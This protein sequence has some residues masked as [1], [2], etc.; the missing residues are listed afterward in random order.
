M[1]AAASVLL[2]AFVLLVCFWGLCAFVCFWGQWCFCAFGVLLGSERTQSLAMWPIAPLV[3][4][5]AL[6]L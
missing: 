4:K 5:C 6:I 1:I 2:G 3:T